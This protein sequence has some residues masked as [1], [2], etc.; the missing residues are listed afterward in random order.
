[1]PLPVVYRRQV[2]R[3]LAAGFG[4]YEAQRKQLRGG[5]GT[6]RPRPVQYHRVSKE[7]LE[8]LAFW[9]QGRAASGERRG[10]DGAVRSPPRRHAARRAPYRRFSFALSYRALSTR[11]ARAT[12]FGFTQKIAP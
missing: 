6:D 4:Y 3:D 1:M 5:S 11:A 8:I 10:R 12:S 7:T 2:G 9:Q